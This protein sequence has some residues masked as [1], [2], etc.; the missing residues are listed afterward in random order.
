[1]KILHIT[2]NLQIGGISSYIVMLAQGLKARGIDVYCA[3]SGGEL[4]EELER[5]D[6]PFFQIPINTKNEFHPK[7]MCAVYRLVE[8]INKYNITHIHAHTRIAQIVAS[9]VQH[10]VRVSYVSTCHGFFRKKPLRKIFP[11]WGDKIIAISDPIREHLV[12]DFKIPKQ[13]IILIENGIDSDCVDKRLNDY[14]K[15]EL[16]KYYGL[17]DSN[18]VIGSVSKLEMTKGYQF[19]IRAMPHILIAY[20]KTKCVLIGEGKYK[21]KLVKLARKLKVEN[22]V[23]FPGKL[24]DVS[25]FLQ[26]I[27]LFVLPP[28]WAEGFGLSILEAMA[29]AKPIVATNIGSVYN[30]VKEGENGLL[31]PSGD[32]RALSE[33]II[34]L[35]QN[36]EL[37]EQ[38]SRKSLQIA[39]NEFSLDV[40]LNKMIALYKTL[41]EDD[42]S[43]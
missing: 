24:K 12:N 26:M 32:E 10:F 30:L 23:L 11:A 4:V 13:K 38:M 40:W 21:K 41:S 15:T 43:A 31:V 28:I 5:Y 7:L 20:P 8:I 9:Y 19:L 17:Y 3:S 37:L 14:D 1:M 2:T 36:P 35:T 42:K 39:K 33:A 25:F 6:I 22:N 18:F 27:D 29:F 16:R 34:Y